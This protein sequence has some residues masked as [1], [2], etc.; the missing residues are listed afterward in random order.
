M[1]YNMSYSDLSEMLCLVYSYQ[2][3]GFPQVRINVEHARE[4][5]ERLLTYENEKEKQ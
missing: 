2:E 5:L 3:A 4:I 1:I